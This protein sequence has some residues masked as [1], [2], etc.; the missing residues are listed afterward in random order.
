MLQQDKDGGLDQGEAAGPPGEPA[1][2][3]GTE[4]RL[5]ARVDRVLGSTS[6]K[7]AR[8]YRAEKR[9]S[10]QTIRGKLEARVGHV[11]LETSSRWLQTDFWPHQNLA[12]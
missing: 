9:V 5:G 10:E 4:L 1:P 7:V 3:G 2:Q 12:S 8:F 6:R 11:E